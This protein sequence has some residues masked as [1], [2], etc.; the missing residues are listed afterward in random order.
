LL[1]SEKVNCLR[2]REYLRAIYDI[3]IPAEMTA[4]EF[5]E[6]ERLAGITWKH[7]VRFRF[8]DISYETFECAIKIIGNIED[9]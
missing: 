2:I 4:K 1:P 6:D 7:I 9:V 5:L 3:S 8:N